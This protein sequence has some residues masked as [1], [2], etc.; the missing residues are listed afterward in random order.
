MLFFSSEIFDLSIFLLSR[1]FFLSCA[2]TKELFAMQWTTPLVKVIWK[3]ATVFW[4]RIGKIKIYLFIML[5]CWASA[6]CHIA[7]FLLYCCQRR[8]TTMVFGYRCQE[9]V[10]W[11]MQSWL[12]CWRWLA[13]AVVAVRNTL[14]RWNQPE[15]IE[16]GVNC[17]CSQINN[18]SLPCSKTCSKFALNQ[19]WVYDDYC[20]LQRPVP[21]SL[22]DLVI[23]WGGR[24]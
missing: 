13:M 12:W 5:R 11:G 6:F 7:L 24:L 21:I 1:R 3:A 10:A 14:Q 18:G 19:W 16:V 9:K 23:L 17:R 20:L 2:T 8:R 22:C 15:I 4:K